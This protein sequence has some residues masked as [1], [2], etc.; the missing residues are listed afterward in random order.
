MRFIK[1]MLGF[2]LGAG[3]SFSFNFGIGSAMIGLP[4]IVA[5]I[6]AVPVGVYSGIALAENVYEL[7]VFSIAGYVLDM[8]WSALNTVV[9]LLYIPACLLAGGGLQVNSDTQR[10]GSLCYLASPRGVG[11]RMTLGP[12]IGGGWNRHEEVHIWQAR[13]FG[14]FYFPVYGLCWGLNMLFRLLTGKLNDLAV[15][16]YRRVCF[17]DWAYAAGAPDEILWSRWVLWFM[18]C[19]LY[20]TVSVS[21][22]FGLVAHSILIFLLALALLLVYSFVRAFAPTY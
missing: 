13:I 19:S 8:S 9:G 18:V 20:V 14:L 21:A 16:A 3:L 12:V 15:A 17:E 7:S 6:G 5:L 10:S 1:G 11:W 22:V 2:L 4:W